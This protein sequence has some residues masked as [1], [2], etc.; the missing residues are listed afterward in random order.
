MTALPRAFVRILAFA[1][2]SALLVPVQ[3]LVLL[4]V[5]RGRA[6]YAI[7]KLWHAGA[8]RILGI[9]VILEGEKIA[10]GQAL[11]VANHISYLDI[12]VIGSII[13]E[14]AFIAKREVSGWPVFGFLSNMQQTA[15]IDRSR[16][17]A[18]RE[19]ETIA[20]RI[21]AGAR[22]ILFPEGT[23]SDGRRILPF[24]SPFFACID[25]IPEEE[26]TVQPL[27]ISLR[28]VCGRPPQNADDFDHYAW[29][30]DMDLAPHLW[31][32]LKTPGMTVSLYIHAPLPA[33]TKKCRKTLAQ[34]SRNV[35]VRKFP[36]AG[37]DEPDTKTVTAPYTPENQEIA[38]D[39]L[40][41]RGNPQDASLSA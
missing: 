38:N 16:H 6:A 33:G 29:H 2:W 28:T 40:F 41:D 4:A 19:T 34:E 23:S 27:G 5:S 7:P 1:L 21:R 15:F 32:V 11:F 17:A 8:L 35:I 37:D 14:A 3:C 24:R 12:P 26:I 22:M 9:R 10:R 25:G 31:R 18:A 30:G 20:A 36:V 13:P 39:R